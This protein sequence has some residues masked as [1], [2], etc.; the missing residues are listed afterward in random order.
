MT[1]FMGDFFGTNKATLIRSLKIEIE[2]S[3]S[4][5][6]GTDVTE[7]AEEVETEVNEIFTSTEE[8]MSET[9]TPEETEPSS[10]TTQEVYTVKTGDSLSIIAQNLLGDGTRWP[11]IYEA[12]KDIIENPSVVQ[13]GTELIIPSR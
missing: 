1:G 10:T 5:E 3:I 11:E 13:V 4:T 9:V 2:D 7:T 12:N 8:A 6:I